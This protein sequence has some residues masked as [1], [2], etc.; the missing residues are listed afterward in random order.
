MDTFLSI[1]VPAFN[2]RE[3][4]LVL[5]ERLRKVLEA[6]GCAYE[7]IV[8]DDGSRDGT[9][10]LVER[11]HRDNPRILGLRFSRNFGHQNALLAGLDVARGHAVIMMDADLQHPPELI[12]Q[13]VEQWRRGC[14]V[15]NTIRTDT[16]G[17]S[18]VKRMTSRLFYR[19]F[20]WLAQ[21]P[22]REGMADFR[23]LD[24]TVVDQ[25]QRFRETHLFLRGVVNWMGFPTAEVRFS[26]P[27]RQAGCSKYSWRRMIGFAVV[28]ITSF[29]I[30]PLRV[31]IIVGLV[32]ALL[33]FTELVYVLAIALVKKTAV[34][35]WASTLGILALLFGVLFVLLGVLGEYVGRIFEA[36]QARPPFIIDGRL[37]AE[38]VG[39][40][41]PD[42][43][44]SE[45]L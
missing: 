26:A 7:I 42:G 35:G 27:P 37:G 13:L 45:L 2:E 28:G 4:L 6:L 14:R 33:A 23:L 22:M 19:L 15:V 34:P 21:S 30:Q 44:R 5:E 8:V 32:T 24:R 31:S 40:K 12:P 29:T 39:G 36:V 1:V 10:D 16:A 3:N 38:T 17:A 11:L 43:S 18:A 41:D 20:S 9:W 25:L